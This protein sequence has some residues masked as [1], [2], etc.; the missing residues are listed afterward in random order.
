MVEGT[1]LYKYS[2]SISSTSSNVLWAWTSM[3]SVDVSQTAYTY[4]WTMPIRTSTADTSKFVIQTQGYGPAADVFKPCP[5]WG[6]GPDGV[7]SGQY[8]G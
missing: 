4:K 6:G 5:D 7:G 2:G 8:C 1:T 3:G